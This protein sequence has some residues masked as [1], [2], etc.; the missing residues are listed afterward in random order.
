MMRRFVHG[1]ARLVLVVKGTW[2]EEMAMERVSLN[3]RLRLEH[4]TLLL[5]R[6][7]SGEDFGK[8]G[9]PTFIEGCGTDIKEMWGRSDGLERIERVGWGG[10]NRTNGRVVL[11]E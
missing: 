6:S 10:R 9:K 8:K 4:Q 7:I 5:S 1:R 11:R 2:V 3:H